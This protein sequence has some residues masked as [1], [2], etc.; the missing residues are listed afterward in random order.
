[1]A[2]LP[3]L[4]QR[5]RP[6]QSQQEHGEDVLEAGAPI[7]SAP[8]PLSSRAHLSSPHSLCSN[9]RPQPSHLRGP[10]R[11]AVTPPPLLVRHV[12]PSRMALLALCRDRWSRRE[13]APRGASARHVPGGR[14]DPTG[15]QAGS[16]CACAPVGAVCSLGRG[17]ALGSEEGPE[18]SGAELT[19]R[20][21]S[22]WQNGEPRAGGTG[23]LRSQLEVD[24]DIVIAGGVQCR[25]EPP[26]V[27]AWASGGV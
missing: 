24:G 22:P 6:G 10:P 9:G 1:M 26:A 7:Q 16:D 15:K 19:W 14:R 12:G 18:A 4:S 25:N 11:D 27:S 3:G 8:V 23:W 2:F 13:G 17:E 5:T 21:W 20:V